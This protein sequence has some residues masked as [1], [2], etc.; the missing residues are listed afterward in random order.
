[1][2][3]IALQCDCGWRFF[4]PASTQGWETACPNCGNG[5]PIS[6]RRMGDAGY[7]SAGQLAAA[8]QRVTTLI[9][10]G[11]GLAA[12]V[13]VAIVVWSLIPEPPPPSSP[14]E[15]YAVPPRGS[16]RSFIPSPPPAPP[17]T[18]GSENP[19]SPEPRPKS[20]ETKVDVLPMRHEAQH[21]TRK[22]NLA[23]V[24][25]E[26]LRLRG[27][28]EPG[29][30]ILGTAQ[31]WEDRLVE[32]ACHVEELSESIKVEDHILPGETIL[33]FAEKDFA[34]RRDWQAADL[35][36]DWLRQLQVNSS[37]QVVVL[38][39]GRE[40]VLYIDL[41]HIP[42]DF[43]EI[44]RTPTGDL[45]AGYDGNSRTGDLMPGAIPA[46][47]DHHRPEQ[48]LRKIEAAF[49]QLPA[50]YGK[51]LPPE[52]K[53]RLE[54]LLL[55]RV[56]QG[57]DQAFLRER[58][59]I[60]VIPALERDAAHVK[61]RT[62]ELEAKAQQ[63]IAVDVIHCKDGRKVEGR[64]LAETDESVRLQ[65]R[66][67]VV[68]FPKSDVLRIERGKGIAVK[69]PEMLNAANG[70]LEAL[71]PLLEWCK[72]ANLKVEGDYVSCLI[73]ATDPANAAARKFLGL[74]PPF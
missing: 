29:E 26:T 14:E 30:R 63:P 36:A 58:I 60:D 37:T 38:R 7:S 66:L 35:M 33:G 61:A 48:L 5:V 70:R 32:V 18:S 65:G 2:A 19:E 40:A 8:K 9:R 42:E 41:A 51:M 17:P 45:G 46:D 4:I 64:V 73:L 54:G 59:L 34:K 69:F 53:R 67:G 11:A 43:L 68:N 49:G 72:G 1:M 24:L 50:G 22:I 3:R 12:L 74:K 10:L 23:C 6:G 15:G 21:L 20:E 47:Y 52:E 57:G 39:A 62:V 44:A 25:A 71:L 28:R 56:A 31:L 27:M 16:E 13:V 55:R